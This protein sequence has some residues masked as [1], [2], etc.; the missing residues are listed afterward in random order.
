M[1]SKRWR[2][3]HTMMNI[4]KDQISMQL[5]K[6][7]LW[8]PLTDIIMRVE[9]VLALEKLLN[10]RKHESV[11]YENRK[12]NESLS[13]VKFWGLMKY[14]V[15]RKWPN[16][17]LLKQGGRM[18]GEL[19]LNVFSREDGSPDYRKLTSYGFTLMLQCRGSRVCQA[20]RRCCFLSAP[21]M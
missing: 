2:Q 4:S 18:K 17:C 16:L 12:L 15:W 6:E 11:W 8:L 10:S 21:G 9:I 20:E 5:Q 1:Q 19:K 7:T 14:R 13:S 3:N